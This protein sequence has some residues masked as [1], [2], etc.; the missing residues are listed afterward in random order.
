M[1][2][3]EGKNIKLLI[4]E[5]KKGDES[6]FRV[7][8]DRFHIK[9]YHYIFRYVKSTHISEELV[10]EVFIKIWLKRTELDEDKDFISFLFV[11]TRNM[12]YDHLRKE[13]N[14]NSL[15]RSYLESKEL[16]S[17][18]TSEDLQLKQYEGF[19]ESI[20]EKL[21]EQKRKIYTLSRKE[22]KNNHEISEILGISSKTVRNNLWETLK[23]IKEQLQPIMEIKIPTVIFLLEMFS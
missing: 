19:L 4:Q 17:D 20:I 21:P 11:M 16:I 10:Q 14:A 12:I 7:I 18:R 23:T 3:S 9:L 22:G 1:K 15:R 2:S 6:V 8:Y 13:A 5:L